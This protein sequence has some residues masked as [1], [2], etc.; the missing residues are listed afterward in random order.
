M[1]GSH[2]T[3]DVTFQSNPAPSYYEWILEDQS[4]NESNEDENEESDVADEN[5]SD[6]SES[7]I[8]ERQKSCTITLSAGVQ[9]GVQADK[10]N[11]S[12]VIQVDEADHKYMVT[13]HIHEVDESDMS[14]LYKAQ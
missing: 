12:D 2:L 13:L 4:C 14:K 1:G 6:D 3:I 5:D 8:V 11:V 9:S 7:A 10:Y